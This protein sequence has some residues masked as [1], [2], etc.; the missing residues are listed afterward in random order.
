MKDILDEIVTPPYEPTVKD[1]VRDAKG[2]LLPGHSGNLAGMPP[3][4]PSLS[5]AFNKRLKQHPEE[6]DKIIEAAIKCAIMGDMRATELLWNRSDGKVVERHSIEGEMPVQ[7]LFVPAHRLI[8][9]EIIEIET[10]PLPEL[11]EGKEG[12]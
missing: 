3:G 1:I 9:K 2:R 5:R 10:K 12:V 8:D 11:E 7:I 6:E 4:T